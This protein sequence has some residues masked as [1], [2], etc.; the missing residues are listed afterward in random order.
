MFVSVSWKK[1]GERRR[2]S[3]P[4]TTREKTA[5]RGNAMA[6]RMHT[7]ITRPCVM[8]VSYDATRAG[9]LE[10]RQRGGARSVEHVF[11]SSSRAYGAFPPPR[12]VLATDDICDGA[13]ETPPKRWPIPL[14]AKITDLSSLHH[15]PLL[16]HANTQGLKS[17]VAAVLRRG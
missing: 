12:P 9:V 6:T 3:S 2:S 5:R 14:T 7:P 16:H 10:L 17:L 15:Q 11:L 8:S 1:E 13:R 4:R